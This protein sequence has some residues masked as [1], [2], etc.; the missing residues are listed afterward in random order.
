MPASAAR[1][2]LCQAM[3]MDIVYVVSSEGHFG[4]MSSERERVFSKVAGT[5]CWG[6]T[7]AYE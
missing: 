3:L 7:R 2:L 4:S 6:W 5:F 1:L